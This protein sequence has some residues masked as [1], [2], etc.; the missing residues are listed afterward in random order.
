[1]PRSSYEIRQEELLADLKERRDAIPEEME[2]HYRFINS[3]VDIRLSDKNEW[4]SVEDGPDDMLRIWVRKINK[5]GERKKTLMDKSYDPELTKE[6]RI[7]LSGGKDSVEVNTSRSDIKLR[8]IGGGGQKDYHVNAS[9]NK[10]KLYGLGN[11]TFSGEENKIQ[12]HSSSDSSMVAFV[13]VNLYNVLMPLV[14]AGYDRDDGLL[15]GGGFKY[16]HQRGF[17]KTP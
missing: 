5:E 2:K 7:Y 4:V 14:T 6:I 12:K 13:P 3:I 8:I 9:A 1:L 15:L 10:I 17:R 16:T 11:A